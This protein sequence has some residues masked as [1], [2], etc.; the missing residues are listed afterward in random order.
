[1]PIVAIQVT[2]E[3]MRPGTPSVNAYE[4]VVPIE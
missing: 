2:H 3:G 4:K 1:M